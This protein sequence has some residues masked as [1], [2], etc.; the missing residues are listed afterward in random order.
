MDNRPLSLQKV[1]FQGDPYSPIIF[2][3]TFNPLL[4]YLKQFEAKYGYNLTVK[5][6]NETTNSKPIIT[7]PFCDDFNL[8]TRNKLQ[9]Q[10]I[11]NDIQEKATS[12]GFV[13]KPKKCR[14]YSI[15]SGKPTPVDFFLMDFADPLNPVKTKLKTLV[16]DPHKFLGQI[17]THRNSSI[18]HFTFMSEILRT[19]LENLDSCGVRNEYKIATYE[20]YLIISLR[21]HFSIHTVHQTHLDKLDMIAN[22]YLK[23]WAGIPAR[24]STNLSLFHPQLMGLKAPSQLYMEG[25]AGN[26]LIC[27][28]KADETVQLAIESQLARET[29]WTRKSSTIVQCQEIIDIVSDNSFFPTPTNCHNYRSSVASETPKLKKAVKNAILDQVKEKWNKK[30]QD[31]EIQ[32]DFLKLLKE[33]DSD[34]T[35][36]SYIYGV[37]KGVMSFAMRSTTNTLA[38]PDNLR[39]WKKTRSDICTMC[40][41]I[42]VCS[43]DK[44]YEGSRLYFELS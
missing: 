19:K 3:I 17:I 5:S 7:T 29:N 30:A 32:G 20:R 40:H 36:K 38:T 35:W 33:E 8:L 25:H 34:V 6:G 27:K 1:F 23:K 16:D 22:K 41:V 13:F 39:R 44:E 42:T 26:L 9:H 14:S 12:M 21:Y 4:Q 31:L 43:N 15:C 10:K 2:L 18:D 24:G 11:Q 28:L 37:P